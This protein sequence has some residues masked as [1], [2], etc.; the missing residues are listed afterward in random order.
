MHSCSICIRVTNLTSCGHLKGMIR[1]FT[2]M[3]NGPTKHR[4]PSSM[5]VS[6][7]FLRQRSQHP[8]HGGQKGGNRY[9]LVQDQRPLLG[10]YYGQTLLRVGDCLED[11]PSTRS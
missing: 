4:F 7:N 6:A 2:S 8:R 5:E 1:R 9:S 3:V 11:T 10:L